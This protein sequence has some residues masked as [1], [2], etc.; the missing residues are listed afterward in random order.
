MKH[1]SLAH[2]AAWSGL[3]A[4]PFSWMLNTQ[5]NYSL[6]EWSCATGWNP[7]PAIA[8]LFT[9]TGLA[10]AATSWFAWPR[11]ERP[12]IRVP[13]QDGHPHHLLC[14]ISVAAGILFA[15]IIALQGVAGL[16]VGACQR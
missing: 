3:V 16:I 13:E 6:V 7:V 8:A 9:V 12:G 11:L 1:V 14:G 5:V 15:I 2:G 4:G 10:G